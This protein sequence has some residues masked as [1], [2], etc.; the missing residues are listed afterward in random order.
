MLTNV[1][2]VAELHDV[3]YTV[4][5]LPTRGS[6]FAARS[7]TALRSTISGL[8]GVLTISRAATRCIPFSSRVVRGSP[9]RLRCGDFV[10]AD[11][12]L[13]GSAL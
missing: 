11:R 6:D 13:W 10:R 1:L 3:C 9:C 4:L 7:L 2:G 8:T 12:P 5:C